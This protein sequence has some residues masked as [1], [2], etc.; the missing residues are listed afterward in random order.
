VSTPVPLPTSATAAAAADSLA[1]R[2]VGVLRAPRATFNAIAANP[3]AIDVLSLSYAVMFLASAAVLSTEVGQLALVDQWERTAIAFGQPVD[4]ARYAAF[5]QASENG[6]G[7][8]AL[9]ALA[10]GPVL[11]F[12]ISAL[13]LGVFTGV[14]RGRARFSQVFAVVAHAGVILALRQLV[15]APLAYSRETLASPTTLSAF[16]SMFDEASPLA[17]FFG[18]IDI[19]VVWWVVA[20]A[21]GVSV[22]YRR[23]ARPL[24]LAFI[25]AY[26][27][28]ALVLALVMALAGGT[29]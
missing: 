28:V 9:S 1:G 24:V 21:L 19:F 3:R 7:Y 23:P 25:G 14:L 18:I 29:T 2:I 15:A 27:A 11:A 17:R 4:D 10:G 8:A 6:V 13:L 20:L 26:I 12:G 22:L 5:Q 16:F